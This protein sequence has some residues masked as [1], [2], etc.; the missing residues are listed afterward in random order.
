MFMAIGQLDIWILR[1]GFKEFNWQL[2]NF[3]KIKCQFFIIDT[4]DS[5]NETWDPAP[6]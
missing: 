6:G 3:E 4:I 2:I 1:L 5:L